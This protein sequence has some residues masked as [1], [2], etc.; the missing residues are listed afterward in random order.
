MR[1]ADLLEEEG[2]IGDANAR[3]RL[4]R[5]RAGPEV[6]GEEDAEEEEEPDARNPRPDPWLL[7]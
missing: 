7:A 2:A 6:Q 5:P 4:G 1:V 3:G